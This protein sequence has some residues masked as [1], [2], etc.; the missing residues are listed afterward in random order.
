MWVSLIPVIELPI[1]WTIALDSIA[2]AIIQPAIGYAGTRLPA[3]VLDHR[4]WLFRTRPWERSGA[5]YQ[6]LF[7]VR[8]WKSAL[9]S[10]G[11]V[12]PGG[13]SMRQI[14]SRQPDYLQRWLLETCRAELTHWMSILPSALFFLWNP[15]PLGVAMVVY[16]VLVNVPCIIVQRYNRPRLMQILGS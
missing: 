11:T 13:F 5:I 16:A 4:R 7:R 9:P 1:Y 6:R 3:T 12:F 15:R 10:G 2:W 14:A 8:G